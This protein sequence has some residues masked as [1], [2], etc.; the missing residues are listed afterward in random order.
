MM[1]QAR[2]D[3]LAHRIDAA[4]N[5]YARAEKLA[6]TSGQTELAFDLGYTRASILLRE[7]Q[8]EVASAEFLRLSNEY[9]QNGKA[10]AAHLNS[11]YCLGRMY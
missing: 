9:S 7:K 3:F 4:L 10:A 11:A 2:A 1:Q 5:G 6:R 8:Y